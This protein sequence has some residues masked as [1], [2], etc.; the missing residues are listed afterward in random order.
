MF[1]VLLKL[2]EV[3]NG[4]EYVP[5]DIDS[6][7]GLIITANE[8]LDFKFALSFKTYNIKLLN[9]PKNNLLL[10]NLFNKN[11]QRP[12]EFSD[13]YLVIDNLY[14]KSILYINNFNR[15]FANGQLVSSSGYLWYNIQN[16]N[17]ATDFDWSEYNHILNATNVRN[18]YL[19]NGDIKYD[20]IYR[21]EGLYGAD[22]MK[23]IDICER[24]PSIRLKSVLEKIFEGYTIDQKVWSD[25][26]YDRLY[27]TPVGQDIEVSDEWYDLSYIHNYIKEGS[28][29]TIPTTNLTEDLGFNKYNFNKWWIEEDGVEGLYTGK[30]FTYTALESASYRISGRLKGIV[31]INC[32]L[33]T[34]WKQREI[35]VFLKK[36]NLSSVDTYYIYDINGLPDIF[37]TQISQT[38]DINIDSKLIYLEA[39]ETLTLEVYYK[40]REDLLPPRNQSISGSFTS[41]SFF[42][43]T[44][45]N[46]KGHGSSINGLDIL[47]N[48]KVNDFMTALLTNF[49]I[50]FYYNF[51]SRMIYLQNR[52]VYTPP[53]YDISSK[54]IHDTYKVDLKRPPLN[55][56]FNYTE[57]SNDFFIKEEVDKKKRDNGNKL[58]D[59][60]ED[61]EIV[62]IKTAFSYNM[63]M[64]SPN[65]IA[66]HNEDKT[67]STNFN[68][69]LMVYNGSI[70]F[71]YNLH[72][73]ENINSI[74]FAETSAPHFTNYY[75]GEGLSFNSIFNNIGIY[76]KYYQDNM[77]RL[78]EG[79]VIEVDI[80]ID[81]LFLSNL[82]YLNG[83]DLRA[84]Y[85]INTPSIQGYYQLVSLD[86]KN[87][88]IYKAKL[89]RDSNYKYFTDPPTMTD[90][91]SDFN[92]DFN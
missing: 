43:V 7:G 8:P 90:F 39:G 60:M 4:S 3:N 66:M 21:G 2:E 37:A 86:K 15:K 76:E 74:I 5:L 33:G 73:A 88:Y 35:A 78:L 50:E 31:Y 19:F 62:D 44:P 14:F 11:I 17:L 36:T 29:V 85:F 65:F 27:L 75:E 87:N 92:N 57:D 46:F 48:I 32:D 51:E 28:I 83:R 42:N 81:E 67:Y 1:K 20:F 22:I 82:Y 77:T 38:L 71:N 79:N 70:P 41:E 54:I 13:V 84:V 26:L 58:I 89:F 34:T 47:P 59:N 72:S 56:Y 64:T 30:T 23:D 6:D 80:L 49:N 24:R 12:V 25:E 45:F 69:R 18:D 40:N 9:T 10:K 55:Y 53:V 68:M 63:M 61:P 16:K 91:N 52:Y